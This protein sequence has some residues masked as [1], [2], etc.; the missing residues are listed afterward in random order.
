MEYTLLSVQAKP[1]VN[2]DKKKLFMITGIFNQKDEDTDMESERRIAVVNYDTCRITYDS[3]DCPKVAINNPIVLKIAVDNLLGYYYKQSKEMFEQLREINEHVQDAINKG[4]EYAKSSI[5]DI[6]VKKKLVRRVE[7]IDNTTENARE[8]YKQ[9][10]DYII[11]YVYTTIFRTLC[12]K[13][14]QLFSKAI[15]G[16]YTETDKDYS[17][18]SGIGMSFSI[19]KE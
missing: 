18:T 5:F 10:H 6:D 14:P 9:I 4:K 2:D 11:L 8:Y 15:D 19:L 16:S 1:Y 13:D 17:F 12:M 3:I 7:A